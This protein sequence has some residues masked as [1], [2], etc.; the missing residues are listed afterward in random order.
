MWQAR[1]KVEEDEE[2][3]MVRREEVRVCFSSPNG[4]AKIYC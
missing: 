3:R 1:E 4:G 2:E